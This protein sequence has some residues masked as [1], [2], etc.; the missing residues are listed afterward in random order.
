MQFVALIDRNMDP[1]V[2][3]EVRFM[4]NIEAL[5]REFKNIPYFDTN[6][7]YFKPALMIVG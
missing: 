6:L 1:N 2:K 5:H 3:D 4:V 7:K